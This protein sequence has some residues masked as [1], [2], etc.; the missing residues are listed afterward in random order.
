MNYSFHPEA[1]KEFIKAIDFYELQEKELGLDFSIEVYQTI[2]R[3]IANPESWTQ[4]SKKIRRILLHRFPLGILYH[5]DSE[6]K[7]IFYCG[8]DAL[9]K[10]AWLLER[11]TAI[12]YLVNFRF[13]LPSAFI[14]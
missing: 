11:T 8:C 4:V 7:E 9:E 14:R 5:F 3:I 1:V 6:T 2:Q 10:R 12:I 13:R